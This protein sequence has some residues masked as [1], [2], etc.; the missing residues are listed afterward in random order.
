VAFKEVCKLDE[1]WEGEMEAFEVDGR[2]VLVV[3]A[4]SGNIRAFPGK[5]PH[6][7]YALVE[8]ELENGVLTCAAHLWQFDVLTG[9]GVNPTNC[10]LVC[11]PVKV[12]NEAIFVDVGSVD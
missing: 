2:E 5:C 9:K 10:A 7:D 11:L 6:Q 3:H 12:E 1:L 4:D 8:G